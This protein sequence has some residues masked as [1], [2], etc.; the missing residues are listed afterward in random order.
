MKKTAIIGK[1]PIIPNIIQ[2]YESK[3]IHVNLFDQENEIH[4][5]RQYDEICLLSSPF[6]PNPTT[7]DTKILGVLNKLS[8]SVQDFSHN[9]KIV[10]HLLLQSGKTLSILNKLDFSESICQHMNVYPFTT[11]DIWSRKITLDYEPIEVHSS[12]HVHLVIFG[13]NDISES[14]AINAAH[15]AHYP[16]YIHDHSLRTRITIIDEH[17][18]IGYKRMIH[19]YKHLFNNSYYRLVVSGKEK[20][21]KEIH[22]PDYEKKREDCVDVEWEFVEA[23]V[24]ESEIKDKI[25]FWATD[26]NQKLTIVFS[27]KDEVLNLEDSMQ[28]PETI[29]TSGIP[30]YIYMRD[31][32]LLETSALDK[33][34][35]NIRPFGMIDKGYDISLP[36]I[37]MAKIIN[38]IYDQFYSDNYNFLGQSDW[39]ALYAVEIN[40]DEMEASWE[41][42]SNVK[43]Q[44]NIRNAL[45]VETKM[46]SVGLNSNDWE[47]FYDISQQDIEMLAEVE[48]NRW[49]VEE[50]ILGWRPCS[51]DEQS[52]IEANVS[53]KKH[54]KDQKIHYDLRAY[55]DLRNDETGKSPQIY[56][57]CLC[58]SL[59]LIAK[60]YT[61]K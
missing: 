39:H 42:L 23:S 60:H 52:A 24:H 45:S 51:V 37:R 27:G 2:Q 1:H 4:D 61:N 41:K 14:V 56:D 43:R 15:V 31:D 57:I 36:H 30:I 3:G 59:P 12:A 38:H 35:S 17:I 5:L 7:E 40:K 34:Y 8:S 32:S 44:S 50:L 25:S 26:P 11:D 28:M 21:V 48:H 16:N 29:Y 55:K 6:S 22:H 54:F 13:M 33:L 10:C 9:K 58:A 49:C 53:L 46:R 19:K 47:K 18:L 20:F